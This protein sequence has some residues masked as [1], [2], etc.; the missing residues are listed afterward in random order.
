MLTE[1]KKDVLK[2]VEDGVLDDSVVGGCVDEASVVGGGSI[3]E[4]VGGGREVV[5]V[6]LGD[7]VVMCV[8]LSACWRRRTS[9]F[10]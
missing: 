5:G 6:T 2:E 4:V 7:E 3:G 8:E 1:A 9:L 10:A